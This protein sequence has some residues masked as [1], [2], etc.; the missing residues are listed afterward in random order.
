MFWSGLAKSA[1]NEAAC[2]EVGDRARF[3]VG[4]WD[5]G[6]ADVGIDSGP[7]ADISSGRCGV[8]GG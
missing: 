6:S 8:S 7:G 1:V 4:R 5:R 3:L 2:D